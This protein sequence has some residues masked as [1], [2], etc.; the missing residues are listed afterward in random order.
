MYMEWAEAIKDPK[1]G[2]MYFDGLTGQMFLY[3]K[4]GDYPPEW[5]KITP[6][7]C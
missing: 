3:T 7:D 1:L 2:D 6:Y 4:L 5:V